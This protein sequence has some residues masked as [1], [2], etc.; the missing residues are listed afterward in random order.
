MKKIDLYKYLETFDTIEWKRFERYLSL[1]KKETTY[2]YRLFNY[3]KKNKKNFPKLSKV[4]NDLFENLSIKEISSKCSLLKKQLEEYLIFEQINSRKIYNEVIL[5]EALLSRS[6]YQSAQKLRLELTKKIEKGKQE[7]V[8]DFFI[9]HKIFHQSFYSYSSEKYQYGN[10]LLNNSK[11]LLDK[12]SELTKQQYRLEKTNRDILKFVDKAP[13]KGQKICLNENNDWM[14]EVLNKVTEMVSSRCHKSYLYVY[15]FL[16]N[17][18]TFK[19]SEYY[20]FILMMAIQFRIREIRDNF[21]TINTDLLNLYTLGLENGAFIFRGYISAR[22]FGNVIDLACAIKELELAQSIIDQYSNIIEPLQKEEVKLL[23]NCQILMAKGNF[24][25]ALFNLEDLK[26][27]HIDHEIRYRWL[28]M[29]CLIEEE[30]NRFEAFKNSF[31]I[32]VIRDETKITKGMKEALL[33]FISIAG[34]IA[35][36]K[37]KEILI[38][39]YKSKKNIIFRSWI[40]DKIK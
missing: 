5:H 18:S 23:A 32:W 26:L 10:K 27:T 3:L 20:V 17:E 6:L 33:N 7:K 39:E 24:K 22:T 29:V 11:Q 9:L 35:K 28:K 40:E 16:I 30:D 2:E 13:N 38:K 14:V 15:N 19:K 34:I 31:K 25:N 36:N 21:K 4:K 12:F 1:T 37:P 8:D